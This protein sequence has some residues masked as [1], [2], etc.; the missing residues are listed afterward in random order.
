MVY[1][2]AGP[3]P[4]PTEEEYDAAIAPR[5]YANTR[6]LVT[7][8]APECDMDFPL[9]MMVVCVYRDR[10]GI[11]AEFSHSLLNL[12]HATD[13]YPRYKWSLLDPTTGSPCA[14]GDP[15]EAV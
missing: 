2:A 7:A 11:M 14:I 9:H 12:A 13:F 3:G 10:A 1:R 8:P 6:W 4:A 15:P 5:K